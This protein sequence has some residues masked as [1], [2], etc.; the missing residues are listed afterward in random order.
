MSKCALTL[1]SHYHIKLLTINVVT[2]YLQR[3]VVLVFGPLC[4]SFL[5]TKVILNKSLE[6][7]KF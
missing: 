5:N 2:N 6:M 4:Q 7:S 1:G 3:L